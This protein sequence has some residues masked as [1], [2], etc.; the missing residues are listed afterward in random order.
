[1][2]ACLTKPWPALARPC[3]VRSYLGDLAGYRPPSLKLWRPWES[4]INWVYSQLPVRR[5]T[6]ARLGE[7]GRSRLRPAKAEAIKFLKR[8]TGIE[9]AS[10][11]WEGYILPLYY[12]RTNLRRRRKVMYCH[13]TNPAW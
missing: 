13:Y 11:P 2:D 3:E 6:S 8:W 10:Q 5:P 7:A 9:P 1:M 12:H 4:D